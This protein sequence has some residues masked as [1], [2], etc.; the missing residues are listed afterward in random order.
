MPE[1]SK[2]NQKKSKKTRTNQT[3]T[4]AKNFLL[5]LLLT[6]AVFGSCPFR[7]WK[8]NSLITIREKK[9]L[10]YDEKH[11]SSYSIYIQFFFDGIILSNCTHCKCYVAK[12]LLN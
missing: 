1:K 11:E 4:F 12:S 7:L 5:L 10:N 9:Q 2:W 8:F 6:L 3:K